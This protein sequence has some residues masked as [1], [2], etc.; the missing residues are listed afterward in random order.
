MYAS[1]CC[2]IGDV[3]DGLCLHHA[4]ARDYSG[5]ARY[6]E[7][8]RASAKAGGVL[9]V[10][11]AQAVAVPTIDVAELRVADADR[12]LQ[13][14]RKHRLKIARRAADDLQHFR[15]RRLLL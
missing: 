4:T 7:R 8:L 5:W 2:N 12:I 10:Q 15:R 3:N 14:G 6:G 13:H 1:V 11:R 9:C